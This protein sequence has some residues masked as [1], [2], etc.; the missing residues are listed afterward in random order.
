[1]EFENLTYESSPEEI[2]TAFNM[3]EWTDEQVKGLEQKIYM[4]GYQHPY[5]YSDANFVCFS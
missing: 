5:C 2:Y 1:M 4:S 3:L